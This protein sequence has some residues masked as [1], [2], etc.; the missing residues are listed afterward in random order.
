MSL[1]GGGW[2]RWQ[3]LFRIARRNSLREN[4]DK[5]ETSLSNETLRII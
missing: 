1:G 4:A 5:G 2:G 3:R